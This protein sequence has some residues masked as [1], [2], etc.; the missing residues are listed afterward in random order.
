MAM[1]PNKV[2]LVYF[3]LYLV[4]TGA[5]GGRNQSVQA[6]YLFRLS[7]LGRVDGGLYEKKAFCKTVVPI[8]RDVWEGKERLGVDLICSS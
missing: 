8:Y 1:A 2:S 5:R 7:S 6:V 3:F 4:S